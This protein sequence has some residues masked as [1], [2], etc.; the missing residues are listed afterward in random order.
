MANPRKP[1]HLKSIAGTLR[2]S[3]A[4]PEKAGAETPPIETKP[5]PPDWLPNAHAVK[6]WDRLTTILAANRLL[7]E[8]GLS[9]L[10]MLCAIY[11]KLV[12]LW[13]AGESPSGHLLAQYRNL[14]NDFGMT[15]VAW[16][17]VGPGA[18]AGVG[19]GNPFARNGRP[20]KP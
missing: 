8:A 13:S 1:N 3:R 6:E 18:G 5:P 12:Q 17:K 11:G 14:S 16:E 4:V 19:A 10:G 2:P 20:G 15:P 7:T 9:A